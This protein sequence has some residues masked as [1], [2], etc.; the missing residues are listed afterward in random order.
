MTWAN[1]WIEYPNNGSD[2]P[3]AH[4]DQQHPARIIALFWAVLAIVFR[5]GNGIP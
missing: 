1:P 2:R 4:A 3:I 5:N